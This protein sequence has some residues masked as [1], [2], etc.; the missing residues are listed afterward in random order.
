MFEQSVEAIGFLLGL[1]TLMTWTYTATECPDLRYWNDTLC[2]PCSGC[3]QGFG[4]KTNCTKKKDTECQRCW[5]GYDYSS[6]TGLEPCILCDTNSNCLEGNAKKVKKC[7]IFS[8]PICEGC[9]DGNYF[10]NETGQHGGCIECKPPCGFFEVETRKCTTEH[11]R[12]CTKQWTAKEISTPTMVPHTKQRDVPSS[13]GPTMDDTE[14]PLTEQGW[15]QAAKQKSFTEKNLP[16]VIISVAVPSFLALGLSI[17]VY[18]KK[19]KSK[20]RMRR[21]KDNDLPEQEHAL[22]LMPLQGGL[23]SLIRDLTIEERR[24]IANRLNGKFPDGYYHW[25]IVA[26]KLGLRDASSDWERAENPTEKL[27]KAY[28]EK[29]GS[30]IRNFISAL[31][32]A[33]MTLFACELEEKFSKSCDQEGS[34]EHMV[35]WV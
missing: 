7:T 24:L 21:R 34:G 33:D 9:A 6:T 13:T 10:D 27:L 1:F 19:R 8:P 5:P 23:D 28:G 20:R 25:Q 31:R 12:E 14:H 2:I 18:K 26:E 32:E 22:P 16:W 3:P 11:D 17:V 35:T 30:N 29:D 15:I 4:V